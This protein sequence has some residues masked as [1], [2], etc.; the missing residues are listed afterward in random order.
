MTTGVVGWYKDPQLLT[1]VRPVHFAQSLATEKS[2]A[3]DRDSMKA[4][5]KI[6]NSKMEEWLKVI[7]HN[8][9]KI[10]LQAQDCAKFKQKSRAGLEPRSVPNGTG[11]LKRALYLY[12]PPLL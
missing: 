1:P 12:A 11:N 4:L 5:A 9:R 6:R 2:F 8:L 10:Y 7:W 3:N